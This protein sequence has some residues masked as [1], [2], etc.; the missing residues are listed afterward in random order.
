MTRGNTTEYLVKFGWAVFE[1]V[2]GQTNKKT[3]RHDVRN[4]S[5]TYWDKVIMFVK[6]SLCV[7][8]DGS[9]H[10]WWATKIL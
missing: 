4:I 3:G 8:V 2:S 9:K 6:F 7:I 5:P 1:N 10:Q